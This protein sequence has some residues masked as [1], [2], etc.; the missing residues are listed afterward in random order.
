MLMVPDVWPGRR[1]RIESEEI[2]GTFQVSKA[3][4]SGDTRGDSWNIEI[5]AEE[6]FPIGAARAA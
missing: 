4:Y 2:D 6:L 1:V 3:S 5:E